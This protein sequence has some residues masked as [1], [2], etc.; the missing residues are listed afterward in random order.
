M[1]DSSPDPRCPSPM[2]EPEIL[3]FNARQYDELRRALLDN[4]R[5]ERQ[6]ERYVVL[7]L[8]LAP[9]ARP[10]GEALPGARR[11]PAR[12]V[13]GPRDC[14]RG[15]PFVESP[16]HRTSVSPELGTGAGAQESER[17][18]M[19]AHTARRAESSKARGVEVEMPKSGCTR[20]GV[21][22]AVFVVLGAFSGVPPTEIADDDKLRKNLGIS[23]ALLPFL[24]K[25]FT[26]ISQA[27]DGARVSRAECG[28]LETAGECAE[29]VCGKIPGCAD[30]P[31]QPS[32]MR[33]AKR[34]ARRTK[35]AT[36]RTR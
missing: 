11:V 35:R 13:R 16:C 1:A 17:R 36:R 31:P 24:A 20:P 5:E 6:M 34:G 33:R 28:E 15:A 29:L 4:A 32:A 25:P 9:H 26:A 18:V 2:S 30:A 14:W 23:S 21:R 3:A 8:V 10:S 7:T 19:C 12:G 27:C 22:T